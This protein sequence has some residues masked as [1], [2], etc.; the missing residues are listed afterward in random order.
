[1]NAAQQ[2]F[3]ILETF[4]KLEY[5]RHEIDEHR[6]KASDLAQGS[7]ALLDH[8]FI[9]PPDRDDILALIAEMNA[10]IEAISDLSERFLLPLESLYP[11]LSAQ[12]R[13]LLEMAIQVEGIMTR[14]RE[15][16]NLSE[17]AEDSVKTLGVIEGNVKRDRKEFLAEMFRG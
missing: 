17:L 5:Q 11:D 14:M 3:A 12:S 7:L 13:N 8:V 16:T 10:V 1:M 6:R 4:P 2:L 9:A 15:K